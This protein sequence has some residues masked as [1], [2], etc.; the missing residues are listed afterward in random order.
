MV[1]SQRQQPER[2]R[3]AVDR[4]ASTTFKGSYDNRSVKAC[5]TSGKQRDRCVSVLIVAT[6][7]AGVRA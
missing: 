3:A 4:F 5:T 1:A 7:R 6:G 2:R